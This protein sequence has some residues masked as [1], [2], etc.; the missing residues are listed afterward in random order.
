[1]ESAYLLPFRYL[2]QRSLGLPDMPT[3]PG[4]A[5]KA[6]VPASRAWIGA[7]V[8]EQLTHATIAKTE[9]QR[10]NDSACCPGIP[11]NSTASKNL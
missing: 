3:P 10:P 4:S 5:H 9:F 7:T 11:R 8:D 6:S 2:W 1:M